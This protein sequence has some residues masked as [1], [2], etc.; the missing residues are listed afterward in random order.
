M[1]NIIILGAP[2]SGKGTLSKQIS[3]KYKHHHISTGDLLRERKKIQDETGKL[4]SSLIDDGRFVPDDLILKIIQEEMIKNPSF[5]LDGFPRNPQQMQMLSRMLEENKK[6]EKPIVVILQIGMK[7]AFE[8]IQNRAKSKDR[9]DDQSDIILKK[10]MTEFM[11]K[12][13]PVINHYTKF[14]DSIILDGSQNIDKVFE[15]FN[16][17][18]DEAI[19]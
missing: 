17:K 11:K 9:E 3:D 7:T 18:Y 6:T 16:L 4:I 13:L 15:D 1:K 2:G 12:T 8:R 5:I 10:R 19:V 14:S